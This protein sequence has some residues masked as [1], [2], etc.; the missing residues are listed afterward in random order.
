MDRRVR[1]LRA[2]LRDMGWRRGGPTAPAREIGTCRSSSERGR[3]KTLKIADLFDTL[4]RLLGIA[5]PR[6]RLPRGLMILGAAGL[7]AIAAITG[8]PALMTVRQ[9]RHFVGRYGF[10]SSEKARAGIGYTYRPVED[11]LR[12][13]IRWFL[14]TDLI[15]APRRA[16]LPRR[17]VDA[18]TRRASTASTSKPAPSSCRPSIG[19]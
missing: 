8:R 4:A 15:S 11:T 2:R 3:M 18:S 16:S 1:A 6:V 17:M 14:S 13:T 7:Q 9:A 12:R 5:P 19:G 10:Y